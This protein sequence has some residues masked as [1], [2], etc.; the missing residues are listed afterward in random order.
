MSKEH[1]RLVEA[2]EEEKTVNLY[3]NT[4][5]KRMLYDY[6][7]QTLEDSYKIVVLENFYHR[8]DIVHPKILDLG[9]GLGE[10]ADTLESF[11]AKT[12]RLD[13]SKIALNTHNNLCSSR[14][15]ASATKLPFANSSFDAIH[16]KDLCAHIHTDLRDDFFKEIYRVLKPKGKV[17]L[18]SAFR[19]F[20]VGIEHSMIESELIY[21]ANKQNLN[22]ITQSNW[23]PNDFK[24]DWYNKN[25]VPMRRFILLFQKY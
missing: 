15:Q 20:K 5:D 1:K 12:T 11:G 18:V 23:T 7:N 8:V 14:V 24:N 9:S 17:L 4:G 13:I 6:S 16:C 22:K 19:G 2:R 25:E 10:S 3:T 21:V